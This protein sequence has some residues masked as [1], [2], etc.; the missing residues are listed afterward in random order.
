ME[1]ERVTLTEIADRFE[2]SKKAVWRWK[3]KAGW[4]VP[5][6][7]VRSGRQRDGYLWTEVQAFYLAHGL[8][9]EHYQEG[10]RQRR[11]RLRD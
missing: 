8:P 1:D 6:P 3:D 4:P 5:A 2:V 9:N 11:S 7:V 10:E